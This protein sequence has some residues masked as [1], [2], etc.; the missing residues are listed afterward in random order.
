MNDKNIYD[1]NQNTFVQAHMAPVAN[2]IP[3]ETH[4][5]YYSNIHHMEMNFDVL[6]HWLELSDDAINIIDKP[7]KLKEYKIFAT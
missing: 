6:E 3:K 4:K 1:L 5:R 2:R 7:V